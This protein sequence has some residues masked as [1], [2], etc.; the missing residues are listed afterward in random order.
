M[1]TTGELRAIIEELQLIDVGEAA[2]FLG[3][4]TL[5]TSEFYALNQ[6]EEATTTLTELDSNYC[7][8]S[9]KSLYCQ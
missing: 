6:Q 8:L 1:A 9:C 5:T 7:I 3:E 2:S 4:E